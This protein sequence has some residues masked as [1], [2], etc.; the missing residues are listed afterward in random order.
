MCLSSSTERAMPPHADHSTLQHTALPLNSNHDPAQPRNDVVGS[1]QGFHWPGLS[2]AGA[3][4]GQSSSSP[5]DG[6][7]IGLKP[8]DQGAQ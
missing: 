6:L 8:H 3:F 4:T 1:I 2:L 5:R 7:I